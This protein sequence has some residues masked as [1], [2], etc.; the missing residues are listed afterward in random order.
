M[1]LRVGTLNCW[2]LAEPFAE[3]MA[4]IRREIVARDLD[5]LGLQEIV[6]RA[7]E[8]DQAA[9]ILDGLGYHHVF[10]RAFGWDDA[11]RLLPPDAGAPHGFGNVIASRWPIRSSAVRP[12]PGRETGEHRSVV[13]ALVPL[14][15]GVTLAFFC[16]H[17]NWQFDHGHVRERQ[18][19]AVADFVREFGATEG[20]SPTMPP[21]L[22]GDLNAEPD[23]REIR[24]LRGL[25]SLDGR[26]VYFQDAWQLAGDGGPGFTWDNRN[27]FA[28][29]AWEPDRRI[30]YVLVGLASK[31]DGRGWIGAAR[32]AFTEP[33]GDVFASDHFGV[34]ADVRA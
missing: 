4:L 32:L 21:I 19:V 20:A 2:S 29:L 1:T 11:G 26:S 16:T 5:L 14:P 9:R 7:G 10:G 30:D 17:L 23:A 22:V 3:R 25:A 15:S 13:G 27:R 28:A 18:V 34:V 8:L 33:A 31:D 6:V 24:F 12:L